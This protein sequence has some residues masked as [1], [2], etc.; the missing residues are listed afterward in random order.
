MSS[1]T[2]ERKSR[3]R[4]NLEDATVFVG[5]LA[6]SVVAIFQFGVVGLAA[7][8]LVLSL[9]AAVVV[10]REEGFFVEHDERPVVTDGGRDR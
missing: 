4:K 1:S 9:A 5:A 6:V 10:S 7:G 3:F 2:P 8:C